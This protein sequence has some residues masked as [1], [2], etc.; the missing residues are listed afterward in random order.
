[1]SPIATTTAMETK[2]NR[3]FNAWTTPIADILDG[4]KKNVESTI[5]E[6]ICLRV[7]PDVH[8]SFYGPYL[9]GVITK[10]GQERVFLIC[11]ES[12]SDYSYATGIALKGE[13]IKPCK[14]DRTGKLFTKSFDDLLDVN[15]RN[16]L[17]AIA[18]GSVDEVVTTAGA[19]SKEDL[20]DEVAAASPKPTI[21]TPPTTTTGTPPVPT[22]GTPPTPTTGTPPAPT[23]GTPPTPSTGTP[24][25]PTTGTPPAPTTG[26]PPTPTTG[27]PPAPTTGTP[28][29]PTT[30]TPPAPTIGEE[31]EAKKEVLD[32]EVSDQEDNLNLLENLMA[33]ATQKCHDLGL[34]MFIG[35][36]LP[37]KKYK[38]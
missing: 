26:T 21:G 37:P 10:D 25:A 12:S 16:R 2:T 6:G 20:V 35:I 28:P 7:I 24:P 8:G 15:A 32:L 31:T 5:E 22:I 29:A 30:G 13:Y 14:K 1:M 19:D 36:C 33:T 27:T 23:I 3:W 4:S 17:K 34:P 9:N 38:K 18:A 11:L